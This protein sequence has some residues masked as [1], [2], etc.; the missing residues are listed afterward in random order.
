M[1]LCDALPQ[2]V[3]MNWHGNSQESL[4]DEDLSHLDDFQ[5]EAV[6]AAATAGS[7]D[8]T[9]ADG[10]ANGIVPPDSSAKDGGSDAGG[11]STAGVSGTAPKGST[12]KTSGAAVAGSTASE[13]GEV[14]ASWVGVRS[15]VP[16]L[17]AAP[18]DMRPAPRLQVPGDRGAHVKPFQ[19]FVARMVKQYQVGY[20]Q[21]YSPMLVDCVNSTH[22]DSTGLGCWGGRKQRQ[23]A[24]KMM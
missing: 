20:A 12:N 18:P 2:N 5:R 10:T 3:I 14:L 6:A 17:W 15:S 11:G 4:D 23:G 16:L 8:G 19:A 13:A 21:C 7:T 22:Y 24:I 1:F 9:A